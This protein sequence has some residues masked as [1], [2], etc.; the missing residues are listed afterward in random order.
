[1]YGDIRNCFR[2]DRDTYLTE[3]TSERLFNYLNRYNEWTFAEIQ[4]LLWNC[5]KITVDDDFDHPICADDTIYRLPTTYY[6]K[7]IVYYWRS[8]LDIPDLP[9][10]KDK[11]GVTHFTIIKEKI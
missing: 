6:L 9:L 4:L 8:G 10:G 1:M 11:N 3:G 7:P 2:I 5:Y